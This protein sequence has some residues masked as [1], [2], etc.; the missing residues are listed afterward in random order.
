MA[1]EIRIG[2]LGAGKIARTMARTLQGMREAARQG[3]APEGACV[4]VLWA[5]AAR[6]LGRA[7]AFQEEFGFARAYGSYEELARDEETQLVYIATPHSHHYA[8]MKL[9]IR[10]GKHVLCEKAFT[11]NAAQAREVLEL[12]EGAGL[13][14][15]EAMWTRYMPARRMLDEI[16]ASGIIG[17]PFCLTANLSYDID[18]VERLAEP[19]LAGGALLD[20]GI[21]PISFALMAFGSDIARIVSGAQ[22][23]DKG[24]DGQDSI[25]FQYRDGRQALLYSSM[26][27]RSDRQGTIAGE[28]GYLIV[29]N[30]NNPQ[31]ITVYDTDDREIAR[32][33]VP[34]QITGYEYEVY[35][36][37][38]AV[39]QGKKECLQMPHAETLQVMELLDSLRREWGVVYP[40]ERS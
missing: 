27:C 28:K 34:T 40:F 31:R 29:K 13:L 33:D 35:A 30:I 37:M 32:Y 18:E 15:A 24:V 22:L 4:P 39:S 14:A 20:V 6:D 1:E 25:T 17:R 5:V 36:A 7:Q 23:T 10:H 38:E 2:I 12:A 9:C 3:T 26:Y 11:A 8:H 19:A 16:L 21:Y